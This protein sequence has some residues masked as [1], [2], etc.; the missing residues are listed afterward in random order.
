MSLKALKHSSQN[1]ERLNMQPWL[2]LHRTVFRLKNAAAIQQQIKQKT[3]IGLDDSKYLDAWNNKGSN[4]EAQWGL[5]NDMMFKHL[6]LWHYAG[7]NKNILNQALGSGYVGWMLNGLDREVLTMA[8]KNPPWSICP[9][10]SLLLSGLISR[11]SF[12][13]IPV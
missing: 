8:F 3:Q 6:I 2:A 5:Q 12:I 9:S 1:Q 4:H 11:C 7:K 10:R 13:L